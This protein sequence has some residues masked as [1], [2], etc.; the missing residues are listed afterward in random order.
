M[1]S[2]IFDCIKN[3]IIINQYIAAGLANVKDAADAGFAGNK[4]AIYNSAIANMKGFADINALAAVNNSQI[5]KSAAENA[6]ITERGVYQTAQT[7]RD[8][9]DKT[10]AL[11]T[12]QYEATLNRQLSDA[13]NAIIE[14]R[15]E[16]RI[17]DSGI[18]VTN[19]INQ[20][21][22]Q[23]QSQAQLQQLSGIVGV[24][25]NEIQRNSQSIVNL[26]TMSSGAGA[27]SAANTKVY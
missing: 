10:R 14:L 6:L 17:R 26:G 13:N 24:L 27:Q 11:I 9:G 21:Q 25:A 2:F 8:D 20:N 19:N 15:N 7:V 18:T 5:Q 22:A 1:V 4:D 12:A 23:A 16:G 3:V